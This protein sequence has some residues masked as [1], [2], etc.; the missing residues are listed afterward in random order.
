MNTEQKAK[1]KKYVEQGVALMREMETLT[2]DLK[3]LGSIVK[4]ELEYPPAEFKLVVKAKYQQ[5]KVKAQI[6][7]LT[8]SLET[9]QS[10]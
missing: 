3:N 10:L 8:G 7:K 9:A 5:E 4:E 1:F 2:E 6:E